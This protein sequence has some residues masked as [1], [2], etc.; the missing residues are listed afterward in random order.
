[1]TGKNGNLYAMSPGYL[2]AMPVALN[3]PIHLISLSEK[4]AIL[5]AS[6]RN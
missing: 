3:E 1:L 5:C 6:G 4:E 2:Q